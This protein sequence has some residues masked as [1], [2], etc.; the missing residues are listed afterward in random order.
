MSLKSPEHSDGHSN[1]DEH[2]EHRMFH[3]RSVSHDSFFGYL[4]GYSLMMNGLQDSEALIEHVEH[5]GDLIEAIPAT[6]SVSGVPLGEPSAELIA[7]MPDSE[8]D[9]LS[10]P[11]SRYGPLPPW[12]T[13]QDN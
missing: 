9:G 4:L 5:L 6:G 13:S 8:V 3:V 2:Y 10:R 7:N 1:Q 11:T 12:P